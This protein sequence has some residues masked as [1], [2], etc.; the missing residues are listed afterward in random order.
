MWGSN[1]KDSTESALSAKR[2]EHNDYEP[3][4]KVC[5][6]LIQ[7]GATEFSDIDAKAAVTCLWPQTRFTPRTQVHALS[8]SSNYGTDDRGS[9]VDVEYVQDNELGGMVLSITARGY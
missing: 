6:Y 3:A 8:L 2:C 5:A 1:F 4:K 7:H 9:N